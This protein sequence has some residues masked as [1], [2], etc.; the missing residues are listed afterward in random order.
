MWTEF[1]HELMNNRGKV[2]GWGLTLALLAGYLVSFYTTIADQQAELQKLIE[3][4]P[5]ALMAFF[6]GTFDLFTPAGF[7]HIEF[8]SY[9]P[10]VLGIFAL[11][12]GSGLFAGDEE[13]GTLNLILSYPISRT[14]LF[15]GRLL[16]M[17]GV[18]LIILGVIWV[19]FGIGVSATP[20]I[21]FGWADLLLPMLSMLSVLLLFETLSVALSM[22]LPSRG[23]AAMVSGVLLVASFF[24]TSLAQIDPDLEVLADFSPLTYYQGGRALEGFNG[25]WFAALMIASLVFALLAWWRMER[26]DIRVAGE[27]GWRWPWVSRPAEA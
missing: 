18:T 23:L 25:T 14:R 2:L 16:A 1:W 4:Y 9:M 17:V 12:A 20:E 10:I 15:W 7:L 27:G 5:P 13:K 26:K 21:G 24:I 22:V 3:S 11:L 8:F 19:G 6:G